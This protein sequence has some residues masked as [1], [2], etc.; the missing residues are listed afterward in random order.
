VN[1]TSEQ[2]EAAKSSKT[3]PG[4]KSITITAPASLF[5]TV[6]T[7]RKRDE[8]APTNKTEFTISS[9][10]ALRLNTRRTTVPTAVIA[11]TATR[12]YRTKPVAN[13]P[14]EGRKS[15][16]PHA[17]SDDAAVTA[18]ATHAMRMIGIHAESIRIDLRTNDILP[19]HFVW[20]EVFPSQIPAFLV[21]KRRLWVLEGFAE[22]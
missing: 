12:L 15:P 19:L 7:G 17:P 22:V 4:K 11:V 2:T 3:V 21:Q 5:P 16:S 9:F 6:F 20:Q 13:N 14:H 18:R 10:E 8:T 1:Q